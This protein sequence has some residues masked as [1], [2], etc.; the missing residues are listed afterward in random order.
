MTQKPTILNYKVQEV[1]GEGGMGRVYLATHNRIGRQV[2]IKELR[3][4]LTA[5]PSIRERFQNEARVLAKLR[6]PNIVSLYDFVD[7]DQSVCLIMEYVE[8]TTLDRYIQK[9]TGPIPEEKAIG[10]FQKIL[11]AFIYAHQENVVH[12]DIKPANIMLTQAGEVKVLDFGIAKVKSDSNFNL[13]QEGSRL[14]TIFY[15]SPEQIRSQEIDQRSDIYSLGILLFEMLTGQCPY[16][17]EMSEFDITLK[18]VNDPLPDAQALYPT[19]SSHI[20]NVIS[21]ATA[22]SP[23]YRFQ[24]AWEF[25][26]AISGEIEVPNVPHRSFSKEQL[27]NVVEWTITANDEVEDEIESFEVPEAEE[28]TVFEIPEKIYFKNEFGKV[29][30]QTV[31][32]YQNRDLFD[33]GRERDLETETIE[34]VLLKRSREVFSGLIGLL[35]ALFLFF[36][37]NSI[38]TTILGLVLLGFVGVCFAEYPTILIYYE[39]GKA[40]K[41][42]AWPWHFS[43]ARAFVK[44]LKRAI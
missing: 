9:I 34:S 4:E 43:K 5:N 11:D 14:G 12:R 30:S 42:K 3:Q 24:S 22:K 18:I 7:N 23:R 10:I 17:E 8:G 38:L 29:G 39:E 13:T 27:D 15:M 41:M 19:I 33:K 36:Y 16:D 21:K 2:A 6:H 1:L 26:Q 25:K 35:F 31:K 40:I 32:V 20:Q 28:E 37:F 44:A